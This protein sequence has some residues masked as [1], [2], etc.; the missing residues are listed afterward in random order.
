MCTTVV[1][2]CNISN[3]VYSPGHRV[4]C[5]TLEGQTV[6][7][8]LTQCGS[9]Y[10]RLRKTCLTGSVNT[11]FRPCP[12]LPNNVYPPLTL[13]N[14]FTKERCERDIF[15]LQLSTSYI[16]SLSTE[17]LFKRDI[18]YLFLQKSTFCLFCV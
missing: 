9:L 7:S 4:N 18:V 6:S 17:H 12:T 5:C 13:L 16:P 2:K 1:H 8:H 15:V 11:Y 10:T 14:K 3:A